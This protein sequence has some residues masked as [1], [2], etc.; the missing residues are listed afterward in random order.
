M[1]DDFD[2]FSVLFQGRVELKEGLQSLIIDLRL[3]QVVD[4][5]VEGNGYAYIKDVLFHSIAKLLDFVEE[6]RLLRDNVMK[7]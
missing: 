1:L 2:A 6:G 3:V 4:L 7:L 5:H